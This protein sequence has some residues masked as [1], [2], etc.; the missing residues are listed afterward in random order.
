MF[1]KLSR[2][3]TEYERAA[4]RLEEAKAKLEEA[5]ARLKA[6]EATNI[7]DIVAQMEF[8]PEQLAEYLGVADRKKPAPKKQ[9]KESKPVAADLTEPEKYAHDTE[10]VGTLED[11][12]NESY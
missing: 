8:T 2:L 12:L 7:L 3:R 5:E 6:E 4:L 1:E 10:N 11:I 9:K